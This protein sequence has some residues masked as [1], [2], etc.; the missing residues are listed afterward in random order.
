MT[1][2]ERSWLIS[3]FYIMWPR[4]A[5]ESVPEGAEDVPCD[6]F[7]DNYLRYSP[8]L[9]KIGLR[10]AT[11]AIYW[12][13]LWRKFKPR[14]IAG[15]SQDEAEEILEGI[16]LSRV[17]AIRELVTLAKTACAMAVAGHGSVQRRLG[18]PS[19][20]DE[21]PPDWMPAGAVFGEEQAK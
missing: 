4:G 18:T 10:L 15:V 21:T 2:I 5:S 19:H 11:F 20:I 13:P 14:T 16:S 6:A 3:I 7:L 17:Y 1:S 8:P 9:F 12:S